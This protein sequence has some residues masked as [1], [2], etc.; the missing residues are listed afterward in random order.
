MCVTMKIDKERCIPKSET[1]L[2]W[3]RKHI[4]FRRRRKKVRSTMLFCYIFPVYL[5][6]LSIKLINVFHVCST[7]LQWLGL[8]QK[9]SIVYLIGPPLWCQV[10][11][12]GG[13]KVLI[14]YESMLRLSDLCF[15]K[16]LWSVGCG[17][18][19]FDARNEWSFGGPYK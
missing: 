2:H 3:I 8:R 9:S 18:A 12:C 4:Y 17:S 11:A 1:V 19:G 7:D 15:Y 6:P 16:Y 10:L 14:K 13:A 5:T